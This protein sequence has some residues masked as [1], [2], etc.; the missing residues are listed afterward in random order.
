LCSIISSNNKESR[1]KKEAKKKK[2][3]NYLFLTAQGFQ[4][5]LPSGKYDKAAFFL[6]YHVAGVHVSVGWL[7]ERGT[8]T[9]P[10]T[11]IGDV[12]KHS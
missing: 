9:R 6:E 2:K 5:N 4:T 10:P 8:D 12:L 1:N 3:R 11:V 7:L